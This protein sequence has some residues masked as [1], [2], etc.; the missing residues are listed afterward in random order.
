MRIQKA[1]TNA[2]LGSRRAIE[3]LIQ[4]GRVQVNGETILHPATDVNLKTDVILFDG[5]PIPRQ[6]QLI[7]LAY[8]KPKGYITNR[9]DSTNQNSV[10]DQLP[11]LP[12]RVDALGKLDVQTSGLML[13]TNDG[14]LAHQLQSIK[15][16]KKYHVKVW[17]IPEER[18]LA[19]LK[20]GIKLESGRCD[21]AKLRMLEE[22]DAGNVWIEILVTESRSQVI[23]EMFETIGHPVNKIKRVSYATISVGELEPGQSRVLTGDEISRLREIS[24]GIDPRNAGNKIKYKKGFARPKPKKNKPLS[25][26]KNNPMAKLK[27]RKNR[28]KKPKS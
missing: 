2:G 27:R 8:H 20:H 18:R 23:R 15:V 7:Y 4:E 3:T 25:K 11:P 24:D 17:K 16:P 9:L 10:Y 5:D 6:Q 13:F 12:S 28:T 21:P 14:G 1:L 19:R 22:T 26:K